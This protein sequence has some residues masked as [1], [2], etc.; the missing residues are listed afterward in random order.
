MTIYSM[1]LLLAGVIGRKRI[2]AGKGTAM[3]RFV[4]RSLFRRGN[5][6][7]LYRSMQCLSEKYTSQG[8]LY[9]DDIGDRSGEIGGWGAIGSI[10]TR[11]RQERTI[12][13]EEE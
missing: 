8:Y 5:D 1:V 13:H 3:V 6:T 12:Q 11:L 10:L 7:G 4:G 2:R 9:R